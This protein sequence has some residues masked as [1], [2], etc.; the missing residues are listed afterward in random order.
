MSSE[1]KIFRSTIFI[2]V[3]VVLN[4]VILIS[5]GIWYCVWF[6]VSILCLALIF[7]NERKDVIK[8]LSKPYN[9]RFSRNA[10]FL[11]AFL[12]AYK[13]HYQMSREVDYILIAVFQLLN[14]VLFTLIYGIKKK[15]I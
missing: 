5:N 6:I 2:L 7:I 8:M 13:N 11:I 9:I 12:I 14:V 10:I 1:Y 15:A 4:F 3:L